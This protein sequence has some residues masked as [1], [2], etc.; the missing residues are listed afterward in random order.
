MGI[1]AVCESA[2]TLE[3]VLRD[4]DLAAGIREPRALRRAT[5]RPARALSDGQFRRDLAGLD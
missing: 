5:A 4:L 3:S 2:A 1:D